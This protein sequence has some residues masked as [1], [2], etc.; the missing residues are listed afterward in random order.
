MRSQ[1]G[2]SQP[3]YRSAQREITR[4][5]GRRGCSGSM[6]DRRIARGLTIDRL[7]GAAMRIL[8][9]AL[10]VLVFS[11]GFS[12]AQSNY[13][14]ITIAASTVLD[15]RGAV[16]HDVAIVVEGDKIVSIGPA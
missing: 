16:L 12:S 5:L 7:S 9:I 1:S 15:G 14:Q 8:K 11:A 3:E 4:G 2:V 13:Q 10:S 6:C